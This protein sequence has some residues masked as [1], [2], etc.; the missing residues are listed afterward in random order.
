MPVE[1]FVAGCRPAS[2]KE[3]AADPG[4]GGQGGPGW[5]R[6]VN[7]PGYVRWYNTNVAPAGSAG[8]DFSAPLAVVA[9]PGGGG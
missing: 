5:K 3:K 9:T 6:G 1:P 7:L 2:R 8:I 4:I